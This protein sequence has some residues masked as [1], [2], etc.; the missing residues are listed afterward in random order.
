MKADASVASRFLLG[1]ATALPVGI[2]LSAAGAPSLGSYVTILALAALI[3][4][5]H[6]FGRAGPDRG[7]DPPAEA[8]ASNEP[9]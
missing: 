1:G 4:G 9:G 3:A 8:P 2:A 7:K 6:T 5:L